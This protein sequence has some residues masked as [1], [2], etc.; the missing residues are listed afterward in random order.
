MP[1]L[2]IRVLGEIARVMIHQAKYLGFSILLS[3]S[4]HLAFVASIPNGM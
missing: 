2:I 4:S 3:S 1:N